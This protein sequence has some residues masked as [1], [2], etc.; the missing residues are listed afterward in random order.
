MMKVEH[1]DDITT[2]VLFFN[3]IFANDWYNNIVLQT[4][5]G[6]RLPLIFICISH[7]VADQ[8]IFLKGGGGKMRVVSANSPVDLE[9]L[10][11]NYENGEFC[12]NLDNFDM[13]VEKVYFLLLCQI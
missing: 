6:L 13:Y 12:K 4:I 3:P 9:G 1:E 5:V 10:P 2:V 7:A 11:H 8:V